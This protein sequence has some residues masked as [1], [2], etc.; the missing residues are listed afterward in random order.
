MTIET[1][2]QKEQAVR[3]ARRE[4]ELILLE[5]KAV[6]KLHLTGQPISA[7]AIARTI[8]MSSP[9][10]KHYPKVKE[11]LEC[12]IENRRNEQI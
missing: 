9:G 3:F 10:L 6:E 11:V 12:V 5:S 4:N 7:K 1:D 8:R 2:K